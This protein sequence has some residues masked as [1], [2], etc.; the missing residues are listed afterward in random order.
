MSDNSNLLEKQVADLQGELTTAKEENSAMKKNI[1]EAKDKEFAATIE[2]FEEAS[3]NEAEAMAG[4]EETI[5]S[6]KAG[7]AELEDALSQKSEELTK[8]MDTLEGWKQQERKN[9]RFAALVNAGFDED[10]AEESL[11]LYDALDDEAFEAIVS[12]WFDK[13]DKKDKDKKKKDEEKEK[14]AEAVEAGEAEAEEAEAEVE[15]SEEVFENMES[16]EAA[17]VEADVEGDELQ[18]TRASVAEWISDN[19]L[20][21]NK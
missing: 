21:S 18:A 11:S 12:K 6:Q 20:K 3:R 1:E 19:V 16:S 10:E 14:D 7:I 17:L 15:V 4:L 9:Q 5:K 2:A 8:A 13:K